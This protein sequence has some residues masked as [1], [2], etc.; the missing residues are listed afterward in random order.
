MGMNTNGLAG[1]RDKRGCESEGTRGWDNKLKE[2]Q[3]DGRREVWEQRAERLEA[4]AAIQTGW[5]PLDLRGVRNCG[6]A[7]SALWSQPCSACLNGPGWLLAPAVWR[8][9]SSSLTGTSPGLATAVEALP[10]PGSRA[11]PNPAACRCHAKPGAHLCGAAGC[12]SLATRRIKA[13][14]R[15][16]AHCSLS[17]GEDPHFSCQAEFHSYFTGKLWTSLISLLHFIRN[18]NL[19]KACVPLCPELWS[20]FWQGTDASAVAWRLERRA[21]NQ[22]GEIY[23]FISM[24]PWHSVTCVSE[25]RWNEDIPSIEIL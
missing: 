14:S 18:N 9:K 6:G 15:T 11:F 2:S 4:R 12:R 7:H 23:L 22:W 16:Q 3:S 10:G 25:Y 1:K 8:R 21:C 24:F 13:P 17:P 20:L 19:Y 5:D